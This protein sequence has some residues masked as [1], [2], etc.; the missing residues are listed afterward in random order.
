M[1]TIYLV[2]HAKSSWEDNDLDDF[3]RPLSDRG[4]RDAPV[5]AG[6]LKEKGI[7][8]ELYVSSTA[9]RAAS[10]CKRFSKVLGYNEEKVNYVK[11]LYHAS[12]PEIVKVLKGL[13][14]NF[15]SVIVFAHN[16]GLTDAAND[17]IEKGFLTDNMPTCAIAAFEVP[18]RSW[19]ELATGRGKLLFFDFPKN[20][21]D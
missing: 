18:I 7:R 5:M 11:Q 16:P 20:Q 4:K 19:K 9:K 3:D 10:T 14:D 2:R 13:P 21:G 12:S 6:R 17:L 8:P 15:Q 1:K